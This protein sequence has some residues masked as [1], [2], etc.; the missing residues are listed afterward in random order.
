MNA[1]VLEKKVE[2]SC[3]SCYDRVEYSFVGRCSKCGG[4]LDP[5]YDQ[6]G[7]IRENEVDPLR[8]YFD[9]LPISRIPAEINWQIGNSPLHYSRRLGPFKGIEYLYIKDETTHPTGTTK[10]PYGA[11]RRCANVFVGNPRIRS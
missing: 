6:K 3:S 9:F 5:A 10:R 11:D 8:R 2:L 4:L 7:V 1:E